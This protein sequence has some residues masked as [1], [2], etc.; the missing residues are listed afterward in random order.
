MLLIDVGR[1]GSACAS[2]GF[3]RPCLRR[4]IGTARIDKTAT[5]AAKTAL[6]VAKAGGGPD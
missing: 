2:R 3:G 6:G 5:A 1:R 4:R